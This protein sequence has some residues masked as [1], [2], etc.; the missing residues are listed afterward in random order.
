MNSKLDGSAGRT[1]FVW[2]LRSKS[3]QA[4]VE[5]LKNASNY[6]RRSTKQLRDSQKSWPMLTVYRLLKIVPYINS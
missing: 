1:G 6:Q 4:E 5:I 3:I 2:S